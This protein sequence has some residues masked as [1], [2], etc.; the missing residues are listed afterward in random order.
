MKIVV[1]L[2]LCLIVVS[3]LAFASPP[4]NVVISDAFELYR[5]VDT[6]SGP[7]LKTEERAE[8][9]ATRYSA[10]AVTAAYYN[11][12]IS[13]DKASGGK[14]QYRN[15]NQKNIFHDDSRICYINLDLKK[16]G[17]KAKTEFRRTYKNLAYFTRVSLSSAYPVRKKLVRFEIPASCPDIALVELNFPK[18]RIIRNDIKNPDGSRVIL[19]SVTDIPSSCD[20]KASPPA[21]ACDPVILVTGYFAGLDE[22]YEFHRKMLEVDTVIPGVEAILAE[23]VGD[24]SDRRSVVEGI[25]K[26]VQNKIRYVA[27]EEG[28]AGYRPDAPAEVLR[29]HYGDC[30]GM[31]MLLATL[32]KR[33]GIKAEVASIGTKRIPFDI[34]T[35]PSLAATDHMICIAPADGDTLFLDATYNYISSRDIPEGI[36]GKDAMMFNSVGGYKMVRVPWRQPDASLCDAL[37][38]YE[39]VGGG[40][41]GQGRRRYSG[42]ML[43][44]LLSSVNG[45]DRTYKNDLLVNEMKP[46]PKSVVDSES[47]NGSYV[48]DGIYELTA[49]VSDVNAIVDAGETMY[50]DLNASDDMAR[51]IDIADRRSDYV[52]PLRAKLVCRSE[53]KIPDGYKAGELPES[54]RIDNGNVEMSCDFMSENDKVAVVKT[55]SVK[56]PSMPLGSLEDWNRTVADWK[57]ACNSQLELI[58]INP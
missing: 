47:I 28:E 17:D 8:Y 34:A 24:A 2:S 54:Y 36:Q 48:A 53:L 58:K 14:A 20:D 46:R 10:T 42:D 13:L 41:V 52:F 37:Y 11:D 50:V 4:A 49:S 38:E 16:K 23:A 51:R 27:F 3:D 25:Y 12:V 6:P 45:L 7:V 43:E 35:Y 57:E 32:L 29:K 30:K 22:L 39:L 26:Y 9:E 18:D 19:F 21:L 44:I 40:L 56:Q 33:A 55:I 1:A 15:V 5:I 31:A